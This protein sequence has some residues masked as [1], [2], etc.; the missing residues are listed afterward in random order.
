[1]DAIGFYIFYAIGWFISL[2]P[3]RIIYIFSDI[4][5]FLGKYVIK[6]R[7]DIIYK[8]LK[9]SFPEKTEKEIQKLSKLYTKHLCDYVME[10]IK[11]IHISASE[12]DKRVQFFNTD[13]FDKLYEQKKNIALVSGHYGNWT[14]M[15][16][17]P[18]KLKQKATVLYRPIRNKYFDR[19]EK[20]NRE[21]YGAI[22]IP[23]GT[24]YRELI[25]LNKNNERFLT[26]FIV[27]QWPPKPHNYWTTFMNQETP[28]FL[29]PEK[30]ATK[31]EA[32]VVF[33]EMRKPKR[34][35]YQVYFTL[36]CE[37]AADYPLYEVTELYTKKL[38]QTIREKPDYWLW[39]HKRWKHKR[40][41]E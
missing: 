28:V 36:L 41:E 8:N 9:N 27:D 5:Y 17:F 26:W 29:G 23:M 1:M 6:Y 3:M 40:D 4:L 25:K 12:L 31:F 18:L 34:G 21:K 20:K 33:L 16:R 30:I 35:Y 11:L 19:F 32:A 14:W 37:N 15:I 13:I 22:T 10:S 24:A 7:Q 38:E 2:F 39:S